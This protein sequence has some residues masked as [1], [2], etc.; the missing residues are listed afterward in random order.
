MKDDYIR[1]R[2]SSQDKELIKT[3]AE[4]AGLTMSEYLIRLVI[5]DSMNK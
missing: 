4:K 5:K 2:L 3:Q 1:I